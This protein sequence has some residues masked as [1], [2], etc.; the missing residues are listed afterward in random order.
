[1]KELDEA[2]I[3]LPLAERLSKRLNQPTTRAEAIEQIT[4]L[5]FDSIADFDA[6]DRFILTLALDLSSDSEKAAFN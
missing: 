4:K 5:D 6:I 1:M 2:G 3:P